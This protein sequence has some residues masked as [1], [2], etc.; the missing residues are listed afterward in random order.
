MNKEEIIELLDWVLEELKSCGFDYNDVW[1]KTVLV[2]DI[3]GIIHEA[4]NKIC[5]KN[6]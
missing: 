3:E 1:Q 4:K 2:E 5:E 6:T